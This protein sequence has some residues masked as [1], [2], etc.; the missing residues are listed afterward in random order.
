MADAFDL[1][2]DGSEDEDVV[3]TDTTR[4]T[5][6][7]RT[8]AAHPQATPEQYSRA[9]KPPMQHQTAAVPQGRAALIQQLQQ[10]IRSAEDSTLLM[11]RGEDQMK[12]DTDHNAVGDSATA[13]TVP[14]CACLTSVASPNHCQL[15][16]WLVLLGSPL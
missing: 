3:V 6:R 4:P 1:T 12:R 2:G 5:K 11:T 7:Q 8:A 13:G 14:G 10:L 15:T 9:P 16:L